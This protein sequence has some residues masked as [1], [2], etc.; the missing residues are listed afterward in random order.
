M[1]GAAAGITLYAVHRV[2]RGPHLNARLKDKLLLMMLT[3][4]LE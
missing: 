2:D 1:Q 4:A 3:D